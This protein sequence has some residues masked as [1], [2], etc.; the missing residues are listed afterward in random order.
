MKQ[1]PFQSSHSY[2]VASWACAAIGLALTIAASPA[3]A[4]DSTPMMGEHSQGMMDDHHGQAMI[5]NANSQDMTK[6]DDHRAG[7]MDAGGHMT[8]NS[9]HHMTNGDSGMRGRNGQ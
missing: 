9:S 8:G 1:H 7:M 5:G 3:L 6:D 4:R 2:G